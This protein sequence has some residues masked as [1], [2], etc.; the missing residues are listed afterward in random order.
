MVVLREKVVVPRER[1][2]TA[3]A[4]QIIR[5]FAMSSLVTAGAGAGAGATNSASVS[6]STRTDQAQAVAGA[7]AG[8]SGIGSGSGSNATLNM[9]KT[10]YAKVEETKSKMMSALSTLYLLSPL[11]TDASTT[12][13][14]TS[15]G[16]SRSTTA[17]FKPTLLLTALQAYLQ[18]AL[19]SSLA[20]LTRSLVTLQTLERTLLEI[21][22]RCQNIVALERLLKSTRPPPHPL[23]QASASA[24]QRHGSSASS[25]S[26]DSLSLSLSDND[27]DSNGN[28]ND[29]KSGSNN[30]STSSSGANSIDVDTS[31]FLTPLLAHLDTSS[32]PSFFWRS[33]AGSLSSRV[34]EILGKGGVAARNLRS[35]KER[36]RDAIRR[37]V[38]QGS[39]LP[40][41]SQWIE[42]DNSTYASTAGMTPDQ[43][44]RSKQGE[45]E[46]VENWEREAAVMVGAVTGPLGR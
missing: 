36:V 44:K 30:S 9:E 31:S 38:H 11:H 46:A 1:R 29:D 32:L 22:A 28:V 25:S 35:N 5:E 27:K 13:A 16:S 19:T 23:L 39:R 40:A 6:N 33:L 14:N 34:R 15:S 20:S 12:A 45:A 17:D 4:Q 2:I 10:N 18:T 7:G 8:G 37:C 3:L 43:K 42:I 41:G 21:S 24:R 26:D